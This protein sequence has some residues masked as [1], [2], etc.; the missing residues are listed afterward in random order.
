MLNELISEF[1]SL[2][3]QIVGDAASKLSPDT[4]PRHDATTSSIRKI[5]GQLKAAG[6]STPYIEH[7]AWGFYWSSEEPGKPST[8]RQGHLD[9]EVQH[10]PEIL[11]KLTIYEW[12]FDPEKRTTGEITVL[13]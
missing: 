4:K 11:P 9:V 3:D 6:I 13:A 1:Q 2:R 12:L 5:V 7:L 8:F 10:A